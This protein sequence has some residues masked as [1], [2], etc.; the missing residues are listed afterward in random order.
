MKKLELESLNIH[1]H[2]ANNGSEIIII[3]GYGVSYSVGLDVLK[4]IYIPS[5]DKGFLYKISPD[6]K[7]YEVFDKKKN[8]LIK[9]SENKEPAYYKGGFIQPHDIIFDKMNNA[10]ITELGYGYGKLGGCVTKISNDGKIVKRI[11]SDANNGRG[12]DGPTVSYL[13][14]DE[15][16]Y[17]SE[18]RANKIIKYNKNYIIEQIIGIKNNDN[19]NLFDR[20]NKPHALR[21]GLKKEI[22]VADTENHRI[23]KFDNSGKYIGW[24]GKRSN[25]LINNNWSAEGNSISGS[26]IGA[27]NRIIDLELYKNKI[28]VSEFGNHRITK[29]DLSGISMGWVGESM[30]N[31]DDLIWNVCGDPVKSNSLIGLHNPFGLRVVDKILYIADKNNGRIKIIKSNLFN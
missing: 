22:Y 23:V 29:I 12:L 13:T 16:L 15:Y 24:I 21:V 11:G 8:K 30:E 17:V 9:I 25:G 6:L 14:E 19:K 1:N 27:F 3:K 5:F 18:W 28:Y 4:N 26:E 31:K 7:R 2:K 20:L 10:Y